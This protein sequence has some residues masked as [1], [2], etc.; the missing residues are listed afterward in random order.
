VP[1]GGKTDAAL[2]PMRLTSHSWETDSISGQ[3]PA[4]S[5]RILFAWY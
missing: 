5:A 1:P 4:D 3:T 2:L